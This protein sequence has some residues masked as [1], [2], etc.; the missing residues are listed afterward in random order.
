MLSPG[1][2]RFSFILKTI[3]AT[4]RFLRSVRKR[5]CSGL[6]CINTI[7]CD[8]I[9]YRESYLFVPIHDNDGNKLEIMENKLGW[10]EEKYSLILIRNKLKL[11][12]L[13][14]HLNVL[15]RKK[16]I[17]NIRFYIYIYT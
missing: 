12:L 5:S 9:E 14:Y 15:K 6:R 3:E 10:N 8:R 1:H 11:N 2:D 16:Y 7:H 4:R 17:K 13:Y